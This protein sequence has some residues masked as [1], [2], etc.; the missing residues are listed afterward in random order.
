MA[1][2]PTPESSR[3]ILEIEGDWIGC[4]GERSPVKMSKMSPLLLLSNR[5]LKDDFH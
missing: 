3:V 1:V 5:L 4:P 2:R